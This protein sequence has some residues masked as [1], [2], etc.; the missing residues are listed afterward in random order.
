MTNTYNYKVYSELFENNTS[1]LSLFLSSASSLSSD[2]IKL[3]ERLFVPSSK[4][5]GFERGKVGPKDGDDFIGGNYLTAVNLQSN[6]PMFFENSQN[7]D[8]VIFFDV[9][10]VWGVDYDSS[11][12]D[13]SKIRS[14]IGVG[15]DWLT[16]VGPLNFSLTEVITKESTDIE[17]S[18]RFNLG[19]TF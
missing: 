1:A 2:D 6:L 16:P 12:N 13:G 18:F 8:A 4:L 19:T 3:S 5:R 17:E 11:I 7:L 9:A 10:N 15:I 14:S